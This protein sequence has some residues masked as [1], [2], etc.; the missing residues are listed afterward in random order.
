MYDKIEFD[1]ATPG[2]YNIN[3]TNVDFYALSY[4][5]SLNNQQGK[6]VTVGIT[7]TR[8]AVLNALNAIPRTNPNANKPGNT[9]MYSQLF[10]R[11]SAGNVVRF[12]S[13]KSAGLSDWGDSA[14]K[15]THYLDTYVAKECF[16]PGRKFSFYDKFYPTQKIMYYGKISA[17]GLTAAIYSDAA[18]KKL[19]VTLNRPCSGWGNPDFAKKN[20]HN[21]SGTD[22]NAIDW[23]FLLLGNVSG[24]GLAADWGSNAAAMGMLVSI[25]RGVAHLDNGCVDWIDSKKFYQGKGG[26]STENFPIEYYSKIIHANAPA[27]SAYTLSYD[28]V[29]GQNPSVYFNSGQTISISLNSLEAVKL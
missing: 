28:D 26:A 1:T 19:H 29:Y 23:G 10:A 20:F 6:A 14:Q 17:N 9:N 2:Q 15:F 12:I 13:P 3:S 8:T 16:K 7:S 4:T 25:C 27:G 5:M 18:M 22:N 24:S 11:N 21:T